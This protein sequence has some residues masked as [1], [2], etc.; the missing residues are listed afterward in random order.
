MLHESVSA[1]VVREW[2]HVLL[3]GTKPSLVILITTQEVVPEYRKE[4][5]GGQVPREW[6]HGAR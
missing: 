6:Q 5:S 3:D 2:P 1:F 4:P